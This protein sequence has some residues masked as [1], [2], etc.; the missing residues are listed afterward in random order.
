MCFRPLLVELAR[1]EH[2]VTVLSHF[3]LGNNSDLP[4]YKD[5]SLLDSSTGV[6]VNVL[7]LDD[8]GSSNALLEELNMLRLL[9]S[10]GL[11]SCTAALDNVQVGQLI[12]STQKFD[13]VITEIF[14]SDC[15][16]G[17]AYRFQAPFISLSSHELLPWAHE[18]TGNL[19]NPSFIPNLYNGFSPVMSLCQRLINFWNVIFVKAYYRC[20]SVS[21]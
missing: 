5:I 7:D 4:S 11:Q 1:L 3:P 12:N 18:R 8:Y 14:N 6:F 17:F 20:E 10:W 19:D 21:V 9:Q 2:N 13:L 16:L 15:A